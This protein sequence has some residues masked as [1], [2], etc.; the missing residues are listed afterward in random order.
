MPWKASSVME[1][2]ARSVLEY[3]QDRYTMSEL[4]QR[5]GSGAGN[6]LRITN[7]PTQYVEQWR[8][9][10]GTLF[11]AETTGRR[12]SRIPAT[13]IMRPVFPFSAR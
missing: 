8:L 7:V 13:L 12:Y 3:E 10:A 4:C 11:Q 5:Y 9:A 6:R 2:K 1:E